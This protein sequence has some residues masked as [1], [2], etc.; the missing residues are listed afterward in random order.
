MGLS[1][2]NSLFDCKFKN[3]SLTLH[4]SNP[5][6]SR[7]A[8][9]IVDHLTTPMRQLQMNEIEYVALKAIAFFDPRELLRTT[10]IGG[11]H[12]K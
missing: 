7:V 10:T 8:A 5:Y 11:K 3:E 6:S 4:S 9:R 2:K 12:V 1:C